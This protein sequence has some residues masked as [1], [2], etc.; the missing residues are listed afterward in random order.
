MN[1]PPSPADA[2]PSPAEPQYAEAVDSVPVAES[3]EA[4]RGKRIKI[5][6]AVGIG[7]VAWLIAVIYEASRESEADAGR[8]ALGRQKTG[9]KVIDLDPSLEETDK[10]TDDGPAK[11]QIADLLIE[12]DQLDATVWAKEVEAQTY[13]AAIVKLWDDLRAADDKIAVFEAAAPPTVMLGSLGAPQDLGLGVRHINVASPASSRT[14]DE[15]RSLLAGFRKGGYVVEQTEWRHIAFTPAAPPSPAKSTVAVVIDAHGPG[16]RRRVSIRGN[17]QIVWSN[18]RDEAGH[19]RPA[20]VDASQLT[21]TVR[22][23]PPAFD[24]VLV[25]ESQ[26]PETRLDRQQYRRVWPILLDD[27]DGDDLPELILGGRNLVYPNLGGGKFGPPRAFCP[28]MPLIHSA[29]LLADFTGD[30][31]RDFL[32]VDLRGQL[33]VHAGDGQGGF[34]PATIAGQFELRT[35]AV[36]TA[37]DIDGD[38][39]LDV[40]VGQYKVPW[41]EG[42]TATPYYDAN[43]GYPAFLLRNDSGR[44]TDITE[45]SG[46]AAKRHR[47]TYG[48]SLAD[49]DDDGHLD[50]LVTSDF[51]GVDLYR[52]DGQGRFTDVTSATL[53]ERHALAPSHTF[54]DFDADGRLDFFVAAESSP[55]V[56]RLDQLGIGRSDKP[57]A[58]K[59]RTVMGYGNRMYLARGDRFE[60][61]PFADQLAD[62]GA[63]RAC[64]SLD[65]ENDGDVDLY[66]ANGR[67]SGDSAA[68]IGSNFWRHGIYFG[69]SQ[70]DPAI[71]F[72]FDRLLLDPL[73]RGE[74]SRNGF[75]HNALLAN[76]GEQ[77]FLDIAYPLGIAFE[78]DATAAIAGDIDNDGRVDLIL[79]D[80]VFD[81]GFPIETIR[82]LRNT[83]DPAGHWIGVRLHNGPGG[84]SPIGAKVT[85]TAAG[86]RR[87]ATVATGDSFA[88]QLGPVVHFGLGPVFAVDKLEIRWPG[89]KVDALERPV[90][91]RYYDVGER[92]AAAAPASP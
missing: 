85:L 50:L 31:R 88:S 82:A 39:D 87:V 40:F 2:P 5:A 83:L 80:S 69:S 81:E 76:R 60:P 77:G 21:L 24:P 90:V 63:P 28:Q 25:V 16:E 20:S 92:P 9:I 10:P 58:T 89:G 84:R 47:R 36:I 22:D 73:K 55:V 75:Q 19:P 1:E 12:I 86:Q 74:R 62:T 33:L 26:K 67:Q 45:S 78:Q 64:V 34:A 43:D 48:A 37:G 71:E 17:L 52:G 65:V 18:E 56:R 41:L 53:A 15:F 54:A 66:V 49:L 38:G 11:P 51:A 13:E 35:P 30:G 91:D 8:D 72:V 3:P 44:F 4:R 42:Q 32:C 6:I 79:G 70:P 29:G 68:D 61:P 7:L 23:A 27:L 59:M 14:A 46:L 57:D